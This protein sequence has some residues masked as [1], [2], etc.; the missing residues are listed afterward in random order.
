MSD[1]Q[2]LMAFLDNSPSCFHAIANLTRQLEEAGYTPL[3][4][5]R[6]LRGSCSLVGSITL[7]G[8][9]PHSLPSGLPSA[10]P[11][12]LCWLPATRTGPASR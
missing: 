1:T 2:C 3:S 6:L 8:I 12:A 4:Y 10:R 11:R 5:L 7:P 9:S